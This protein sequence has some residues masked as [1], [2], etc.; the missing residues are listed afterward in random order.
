MPTSRAIL[1]AA[2][3]LVAPGFAQAQGTRLD[4]GGLKQ[5]PTAPIEMASDQ[6][7]VNQTDGTAIFTGNVTIA[8]G[9]MRLSAAEVRV[10]YAQTDDGTANRISELEAT[11]GVVLV[12]G[13][14]AAESEE[15]VYSVDTGIIVMTGDVL[16]SQGQSALTAQ[17]MRVDLTSGAATMEGRVRTVLK[18]GGN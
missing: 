17:S 2:F 13:T 7:Q 1:F 10:K 8:Q 3:L 5:D 14:D 18:T 15:A 16:L 12:N 11:G 6:L 9:E 4:F